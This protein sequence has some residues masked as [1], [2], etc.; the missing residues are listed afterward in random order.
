MAPDDTPLTGFSTVSE[1]AREQA[2][3]ATDD[4]F[5]LLKKAISSCPSGGMEVGD[6]LKGYAEKNIAATHEFVKQL[7]QARDFADVLR[8][9]TEFMKSQVTA[10]GEQTKNLREVYA[11]AAADVV[12]R[13]KIVT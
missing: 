2:L 1:Q 3:A 9:Q 12:S 6:K 11:K 4:Y 8:I 5:N 13:F 10:L 7:S